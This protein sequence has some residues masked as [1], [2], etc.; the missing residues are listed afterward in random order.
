MEHSRCRDSKTP[1][2]RIW[3]SAKLA[4]SYEEAV[5]ID[6]RL[7]RAVSGG[8]ADLVYMRAADCIRRADC[9]Y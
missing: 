6:V 7:Y 9:F 4:A 1:D 3:H 8:A 2:E 5:G